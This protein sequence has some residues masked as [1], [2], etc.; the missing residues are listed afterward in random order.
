[1][2]GAKSF[3]HFGRAKQMKCEFLTTSPVNIKDGSDDRA[4]VELEQA[5]GLPVLAERF[6]KA[7]GLFPGESD[8]AH[9]CD[10]DRPAKDRTDGESQEND[11]SRD[12][13]MFK[14]EKEPAA[15]NAF[16]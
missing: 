7:R 9:F 5:H 1:E 3:I 12:G 13:G 2:T 4:R 11:F 15:S 6:K 10:H 16:R 14:S 8:F